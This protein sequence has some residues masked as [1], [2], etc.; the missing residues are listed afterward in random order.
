MPTFFISA[1]DT[2]AGK[3]LA[4]GL[5]ARHLL[6]AG[7]KVIT[8]KLAQTG[9]T[10]IASD[11]VEHRSIMGTR[12]S[13]DDRAGKT[14]PYIFAHPASP[15]LSAAMEDRE[16]QPEVLSQTITA[17]EQEYDYVLVE[18]AGGLQVP[19][20]EDYTI[21]D[22]LQERPMTVILVC[23]SKLGSINHS[24]LSLE[25]LKNRNIPFSGIIYNQFPNRD[26][27]ITK[28]SARI[29]QKYGQRYFPASAYC[30][31]PVLNAICSISFPFDQILGLK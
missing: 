27:A 30:E 19:L 7:R 4:T 1:I 25:C 5:L 16:I 13:E 31:I 21:L 14:C 10:D 18:G 11:I 15:H 17:L 20:K 29:I 28:E 9:C 6:H 23:N 22:F 12:V 3:T 26:K 2:D 24:L 8:C